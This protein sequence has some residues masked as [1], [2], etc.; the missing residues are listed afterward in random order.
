MLF[1]PIELDLDK[2]RPFKAQPLIMVLGRGGGPWSR[3]PL[4][5]CDHAGYF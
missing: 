2:K 3:P 4:R 5:V 1:E